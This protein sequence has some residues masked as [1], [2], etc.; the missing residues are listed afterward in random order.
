MEGKIKK[1]KWCN[2]CCD[3]FPLTDTHDLCMP[4]LGEGHWVDSYPHCQKFTPRSKKATPLSSSG[5]VPPLKITGLSTS[6]LITSVLG[7]VP[8][9]LPT[10]DVE[11]APSSGTPGSPS[12]GDQ[13]VKTVKITLKLPSPGDQVVSSP[14]R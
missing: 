5:P 2:S 10:P 8:D 7:K 3:K 14:T 11:V 1:I 13:V 6:M 9:S 12:V 4:C